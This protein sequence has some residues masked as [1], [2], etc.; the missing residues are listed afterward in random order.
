M[1]VGYTKL[2]GLD[3]AKI[4]AVV[5]PVLRAHRV[6]GVELLWVGDR[7]GQVLRLTIERTDSSHPGAGITVDLCAE[8]SRDLSAALDVAEVIHRAYQLEVGS[9]GV[10]RPLHLLSDFRRFAGQEAKLRLSFAEGGV[11]PRS[12]RGVLFGTTDDAV[13]LETETGTLT[14]PF[15]EIESARL[16]FSWGADKKKGRAAKRPPATRKSRASASSDRAADEP[17]ADLA[18][19]DERSK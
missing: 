9:P 8:I 5:E 3:A 16:I 15:G 12:L 6:E 11:R 1:T 10:E 13:L 14:I 17:S 7:G 4:L 2:P 19:R 18:G